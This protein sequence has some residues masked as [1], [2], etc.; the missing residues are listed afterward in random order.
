MWYKINKI[1]WFVKKENC[2]EEIRIIYNKFTGKP[3]GFAYM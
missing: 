3:K 2:I 1:K